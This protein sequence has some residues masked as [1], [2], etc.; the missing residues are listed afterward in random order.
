M[1][2]FCAPS[3][4]FPIDPSLSATGESESAGSYVAYNMGQNAAQP[5]RGSSRPSTAEH[6]TSSMRAE[7]QALTARVSMLQQ[8]LTDALPADELQQLQQLCGKLEALDKVTLPP[9]TTAPRPHRSHPTPNARLL[10]SLCASC[11]G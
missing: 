2:T 7:V 1:P 6:P 9:Y 8:Q 10:D 4:I 11:A 5:Y 3:N